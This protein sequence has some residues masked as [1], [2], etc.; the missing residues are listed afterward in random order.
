MKYKIVEKKKL[1]QIY[2]LLT[3]LYVGL[4]DEE[5]KKVCKE[6]YNEITNYIRNKIISKEL[7]KLFDNNFDLKR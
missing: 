1:S 2:R 7:R 6:E 4:D 5:I 3:F